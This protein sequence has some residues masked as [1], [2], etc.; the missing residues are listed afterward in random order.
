MKAI[1][2]IFVI[3]FS[4]MTA[5]IINYGNKTL[6]ANEE[7]KSIQFSLE[8]DGK[9]ELSKEEFFQNVYRKEVFN[10]D[11]FENDYFDVI[12]VDLSVKSLTEESFLLASL[13]FSIKTNNIIYEINEFLSGNYY[14]STGIESPMGDAWLIAPPNN[15]LEEI[16]IS[17]AYNPHQQL[18][19]NHNITNSNSKLMTITFLVDKEFSFDGFNLD[20]IYDGTTIGHNSYNNGSEVHDFESLLFK[21]LKV[22]DPNAGPDASLKSLQVK[23]LSE[24]Y[25]DLSDNIDLTQE[26]TISY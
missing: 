17:L 26:I 16:P 3:I 25:L 8:I 21:S 2:K 14:S 12:D 6:N 18:G 7:N 23:G 13:D 15:N 11:T 9:T 4:L 20:F 19:I 22:D 1:K 24:T 5:V 10:W